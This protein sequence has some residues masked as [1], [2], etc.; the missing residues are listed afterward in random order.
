MFELITK[1]DNKNY[2]VFK[3]LKSLLKQIRKILDDDFNYWI[4][5]ENLAEEN[6]D[7]Q[8]IDYLVDT[9]DNWDFIVKVV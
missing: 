3:D 4:F 8:N 5:M 9:C 7:Y 6:E 1:E 2:G